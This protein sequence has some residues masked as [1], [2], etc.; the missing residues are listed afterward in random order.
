MMVAT[1]LMAWIVMMARFTI[2]V[3]IRY[4]PST[5]ESI[6]ETVRTGRA[7]TA[8]YRPSGWMALSVNRLLL[9]NVSK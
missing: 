3:P 4:L 9:T 8:G 1:Q 7:F 2:L 6:F 5:V